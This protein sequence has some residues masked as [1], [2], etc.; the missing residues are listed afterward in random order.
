MISPSSG[1]MRARMDSS[2]KYSN[3]ERVVLLDSL[4]WFRASAQSHIDAQTST[5]EEIYQLVSA[6]TTNVGRLTIDHRLVYRSARRGRG[7][8]S[9]IRAVNANPHCENNP[10]LSL[11]KTARNSFD[12]GPCE[13]LQQTE[14]SRPRWHIHIAFVY[15]RNES[16]ARTTSV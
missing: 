4:V 10:D 11:I 13:R 1:Y 5:W 6:R 7:I 2:Q 12:T 16:G 9:P 3:R 15:L 8:S 14:L